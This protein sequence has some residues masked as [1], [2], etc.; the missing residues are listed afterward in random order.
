MASEG[1]E[2]EQYHREK[3][4]ERSGASSFLVGAG[5]EARSSWLF[6]ARLFLG[7]LVGCSELVAVGSEALK[8]RGAF[9]FRWFF[10]TWLGSGLVNITRKDD[11]AEPCVYR[12][13]PL[14]KRS[15]D[16]RQAV[17]CSLLMIRM[18]A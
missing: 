13:A 2:P 15:L 17:G 6:Q 16:P 12:V 18:R 8:L 4:P 9:G 3:A 11:G 10:V 14:S 7:L 5:A 1:G